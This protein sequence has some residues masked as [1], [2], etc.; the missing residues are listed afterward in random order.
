MVTKGAKKRGRENRTKDRMTEV[1]HQ[2]NDA[3]ICVTLR[4]ISGQTVPKKEPIGV[5]SSPWTGGPKRLKP[6]SACVGS[7]LIRGRWRTKVGAK[8]V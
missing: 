5:K 7:Q 4:S 8:V 3:V 2:K 1:Y 6:V